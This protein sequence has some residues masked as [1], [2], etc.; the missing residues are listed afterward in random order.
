MSC[1]Q[2]SHTVWEYNRHVIFYAQYRK[3]QIYGQE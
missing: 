3:K 1:R 2:L